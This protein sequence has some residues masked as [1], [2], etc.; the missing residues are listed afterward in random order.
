MDV[1]ADEAGDLL[2]EEGLDLELI[3]FYDP[4]TETLHAVGYDGAPAR[5]FRSLEGSAPAD[6]RTGPEEKTVPEKGP[7]S[8]LDRPGASGPL[9]SSNPAGG[10]RPLLPMTAMAGAALAVAS[11]E[12]RP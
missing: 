2:S 12:H 8:T 4:L 5:Y 1:V 3:V 10:E 11:K 6:R 9:P 7:A